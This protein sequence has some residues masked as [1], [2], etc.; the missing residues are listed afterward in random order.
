MRSRHLPQP[1]AHA[2]ALAFMYAD[3]QLEQTLLP[4]QFV[5][6]YERTIALPQAL[7]LGRLSPIFSQIALLA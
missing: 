2:L 6:L 1:N 3:S 7:H 4:Q 5:F